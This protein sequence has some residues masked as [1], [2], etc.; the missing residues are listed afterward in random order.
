MGRVL[1]RGATGFHLWG[2][3]GVGSAVQGFREVS[4]HSALGGLRVRGVKGGVKAQG[5]R[6]GAEV[7][8]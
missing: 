3:N 2:P 1:P 8:L 6:R 7:P 5:Q 4:G